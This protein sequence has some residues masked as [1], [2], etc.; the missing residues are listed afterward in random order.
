V[1]L[2]RPGIVV[3]AVLFAVATAGFSYHLGLARR[4]V[5]A[6]PQATRGQAFGLVTTGMMTV[7]GAAVAVAGG[8]AELLPPG[9]V[10]AIAGGA[11][12]LATAALFPQLRG[13]G[14]AVASARM[15][16]PRAGG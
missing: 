1:F 8:L 14:S 15:I 10:M 6:V 5:D 2:L 12:L 16:R 11:S 13:T 9:T 3:S 7:Q 4:F